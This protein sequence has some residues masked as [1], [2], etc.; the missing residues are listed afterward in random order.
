MEYQNHKITEA[1]CAFRFNPYANKWDVTDYAMFYNKVKD[2]GFSNKQEI[3]PVQISFQQKPDEIHN[4]PQTQEGDI[5]MVFKNNVGNKA[6]LLGPNFISFH[7][8]NGYLGWEIF[9]G[10]FIKEILKIYFDLGFGNYLLNAQMLYINNFQLENNQK[11]SDYLTFVPQ[12]ENFGQG[13]EL[14]HLFQSVY[15]IAPNKQLQ[16]KTILNISNPDRMK[17]VILECNCIA[18]NT[19]N[20]IDWDTLSK[21]AHDAA[22]NAFLNVSTDIFKEKIK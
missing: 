10:N 2:L 9:S 1:V 13:E 19:H 4:N 17:N 6:I 20:N 12:S 21:D 5:Q 3:R 16:I 11:L 18:T 7:S 15:H 8:L 22:K 14:S